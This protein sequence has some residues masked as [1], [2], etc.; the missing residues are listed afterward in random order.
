MSLSQDPFAD[1]PDRSAIW[2][3]LVPRDIRAYVNAD[4]SMVEDDFV[5]DD[6]LG[7]HGNKTANPDGW[8]ISFPTL[9]HY[10]EEWLRQ[11]HEGR[12]VAYAEDV[13]AGIHRAT[14]LTEI[15]ISGDRAVAHKKFDGEIK[16][17]DG[18]VDRLNWQTLYF[19][20]KVEGRWKLTG[21]V[22]YL[23]Y[24]MGTPG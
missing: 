7:L 13:E 1:D 19:C 9:A 6:F 3:M 8:T 14:R 2:T 21:F 10:R 20:R 12:A 11:A 23:P 18:G 24:P 4:W 16:L 5:A 17:A 15:E 22:G